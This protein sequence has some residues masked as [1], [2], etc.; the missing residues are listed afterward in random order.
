MLSDIQNDTDKEFKETGDNYIFTTTVNYP[1]NSDLVKQKIYFDKKLNPSKV[2]VLNEND[3][4]LI[5]MTFKKVDLK[6]DENLGIMKNPSNEQ[7]MIYITTYSFERISPMRDKALKE[8][9]QEI[10]K[11]QIEYA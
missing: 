10:L 1:N 3:D 7:V 11:N 8:L 6:A 4:V 5:K 9:K 2:E